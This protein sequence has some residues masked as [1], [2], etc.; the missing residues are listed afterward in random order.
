[1]IDI[2]IKNPIVKASV[3]GEGVTRATYCRQDAERGDREYIMSRGDLVEF[4]TNPARWLLGVDTDE[5]KAT[6]YGTLLDCLVLTPKRFQDEFSVCPETY[7]D[8]KT[9]KPKPWTFQAD[10]CKEWREEQR[11]KQ[12][13]KADELRR[14]ENA[15]KFLL[16][17]PKIYDLL[18]CS[19]AQVMVMGEYQDDETGL[20]V[21][22]KGLIDLVPDKS[23]A[24]GK[25]LADFKTCSNGHPGAWPR[26]VFDFGYHWQ[27]ALYLDL[28]TAAT[29]EGRIEFLHVLQE[30]SP[31]WAVGRRLLSAEFLNLGRI[32]Y[33][34][35][36]KRYCRCLSNGEWP[37]YDDEGRDCLNGWTLVGPAA[38]MVGA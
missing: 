1:M 27:A 30:S 16:G 15:V 6:E 2:E 22:L 31:P 20:V 32:Q 34:T 8:S 3:V 35:A 23:S 19:K 9:G 29:G 26:A 5:T 25:S 37:G 4:N 18:A 36:L 11:G 12:V 33:L 21:P 38:W 28:Y 10:F 24:Y 17:D 14:A 13:V 7:P